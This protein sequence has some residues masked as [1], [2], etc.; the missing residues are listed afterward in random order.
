MTTVQCPNCSFNFVP[1]EGEALTTPVAGLTRVQKGVLDAI[2]IFWRG[3]RRSPTWN[4]VAFM[5]GLRARGC[6]SEHIKAL[7]SRGYVNQGR[8]GLSLV[9]P[10]DV[11]RGLPD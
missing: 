9:N 11:F 3:M 4:E 6:C 10:E 5:C 2:A 7:K 1:R 8:G